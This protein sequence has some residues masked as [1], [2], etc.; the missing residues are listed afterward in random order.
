M[1]PIVR[2]AFRIFA[3]V[4]PIER[5]KTVENRTE[6]A[7]IFWGAYG[8]PDGMYIA[9]G[10]KAEG[11]VSIVRKPS[12][13]LSAEETLPTQGLIATSPVVDWS[14][15]VRY[16]SY[17]RVNINQGRRENWILLC[18]ARG[19]RFRALRWLAAVSMMGTF[20]RTATG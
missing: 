17:D 15:D 5:P 19:N 6:K 3:Y 10:V 20:R 9:Y 1:P 7:I 18:L 16:L 4:L 2:L 13:G 12:D 11:N 14:P 8:S